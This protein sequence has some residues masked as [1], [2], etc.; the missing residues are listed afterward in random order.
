MLTAP[1]GTLT[2]PRTKTAL[3]T[4]MTLGTKATLGG[5]TTLR[6]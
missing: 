3:G 2:I 6:T 4:L 5:L 1:T